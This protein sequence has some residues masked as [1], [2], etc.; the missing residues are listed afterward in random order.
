M[1]YVDNGLTDRLPAAREGIASRG[2]AYPVFHDTEGK[3]LLA[4]G[5]R[6]F[7]TGYLIGKDGRVLWEGNPLGSEAKVEE[8]IVKAL[9]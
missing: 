5:V 8:E 1:I 3:T 4:Y 2:I 9:P 7:P 6:A